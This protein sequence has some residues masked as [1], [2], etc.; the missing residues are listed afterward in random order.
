MNKELTFNGFV[1]TQTKIFPIYFSL[2]L[3]CSIII[4]YNMIYSE[5]KIQLGILIFGVLMNGIQLLIIEPMVNK[6]LDVYIKVRKAEGE[7]SDTKKFKN[8]RRNFG[9]IH[10]ISSLLNLGSFFVVSYHLC[11]IV[12][13]VAQVKL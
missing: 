11:Y 10:G 13:K 9:K 4:A 1:K 2:Q 8:A 6:K 7:T 3:L 12:S 5:N